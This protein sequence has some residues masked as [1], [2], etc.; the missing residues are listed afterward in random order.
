MFVD[1]P[2]GRSLKL[3]DGHLINVHELAKLLGSYHK[4]HPSASKAVLF[5]ACSS[6]SHAIALSFYGVPSI[7]VK[8]K[9]GD[10][11][12]QQF[13]TAFFAS[14]FD[15]NYYDVLK[16]FDDGKE[17]VKFV[18][19]DNDPDLSQY[20]LYMPQEEEFNVA[21]EPPAVQHRPPP[22]TVVP[23]VDENNLSELVRRVLEE[24][25]KA[26]D[27]L[28]IRWAISDTRRPT[29]SEVNQALYAMERAGAVAHT[30]SSKPLWKLSSTATVIPAVAAAAPPPQSPPAAAPLTP[31]ARETA[32]GY[33]E[34]AALV[35]YV[36]E[37][38]DEALDLLQI[39][40]AISD[41]RRPTASEVNQVLYAMERAG[42]V[43][44][45]DPAA[46]SSKTLWKL[47]PS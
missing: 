2:G 26:L 44:R 27:K 25:D 11:D 37:A 7:G 16:A 1:R 40:W 38:S 46:S 32:L 14:M 12:A 42:A 36:L 45:R 28:Q 23:D 41:T 10:S 24:S 30:S 5:N 8:S 13:S 6:A 34:M 3:G 35:R 39:R 19:K 43:A 31:P 9:V 47:L 33:N 4:K 15:E 22:P 21:S 29:A 18:A 17:S 20:Q